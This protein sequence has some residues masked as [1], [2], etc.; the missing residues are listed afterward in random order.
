MAN[1][2]SKVLTAEQEMKLRQPIEEHVGE[3]QAKIN[4]L[5]EDGTDQVVS[6]QNKI[7]GIRRD[8]SRTKSERE[9][10]IAKLQ[11]ELETAKAVEAK[12]KDEISKLI[13]RAEAYLKEHFDKDYYESVKASCEA[14]K[15]EAKAAYQKRL[16]ELEK[17]HKETVAKLSDHQEVKDENYV[18]K[19]RQFDAKVGLEQN[20]QQIKDRRHAAYT[21]KYHLIDMLRMSKFTFLETTAQ[22][23][24]NYKYTFNR[25]A[26]LLQ[27]GLYIAIILIF[28]ALCVITPMVKGAPLLT[29]NNV[30]NILQQ[31]SPRMFLAL[32]V[33][34]LILLAC[35]LYTSTIHLEACE[36]VHATIAKIR[37][38]GMKAGLSICPETDTEELAP[39]L[40]EID[41]V[42]YTHLPGKRSQ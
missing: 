16:A 25:R 33:A 37:E 12:N 10:A 29:Y 7:D 23:W 30:L 36:D 39:Y 38:C 40:K 15:A 5:R 4:S 27:N 3:I 2:N 19:N 17:E 13:A 34:G 41:T 22:K 32:G 35:L 6:L 21:Y 8:K 28:V 14:E 18:Y 1:G 31:A 11:K 9:S 24:E 20:L 42:S 26:F